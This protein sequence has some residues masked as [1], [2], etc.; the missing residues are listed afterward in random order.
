MLTYKTQRASLFAYTVFDKMMPNDKLSRLDSLLDFS[1][2]Y[3]KAKKYYCPDNGRPSHDPVVMFKILFLGFLYNISGEQNLL[4]E[5][6]DRAS[7]RQFIGLDL[8]DDIPDRTTLVKFRMKLG[9]EL[10]QNF[11]DYVLQ[12]CISLNLV[13][14]Q[15]SVFD[16]TVIRAKA[17][18]KSGRDPRYVGDLVKK[19]AKKYCQEYYE[20][21]ND[22]TY[23]NL[24][25][26]EYPKK[27]KNAK[28][29][30]K[31]TEKM[32]KLPTGQLFSKGDPD[33]KFTKRDGK[34]ILGYQVGYKTDI[35]EGIITN[36]VTIPA[37]Q[38]IGEEYYQILTTESRDEQITADKEF[39]RNKILKHCDDNGI[40]CNIPIKANIPTNRVLDKSHFKY[41][42]RKDHYLCPQGKILSR[43]QVHRNEEEIYYQ[44]NPKDCQ[45]CSI[46]EKCTTGKQRTVARSFYEGLYQKHKAY[47][48]TPGYLKAQILRKIIAEGKFNEAKNHLGLKLA[49]YVGLTMMKLQAFFTAC[50]QNCARLLRIVTAGGTI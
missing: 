33:A 27:R 35:K 12:Q 37:N 23:V 6:S 49:R 17:R 50:V 4:D 22:D 29:D 13:G 7:F 28:R 19:K 26:T 41:S 43:K 10:I 36:V 3:E 44:A 5:V 20:I 2:I 32:I 21:N 47:T 1:I 16:G 40:K 39:Y 45:R 18:M 34:A 38:N 15:N 46:K 9:L 48:K 31:R 24:T 11:F 8:T 14:F 42:K 30:T 25:K